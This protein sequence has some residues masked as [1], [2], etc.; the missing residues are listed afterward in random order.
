MVREGTRFMLH[1]SHANLVFMYCF[2]LLASF[3][4]FSAYSK[5]NPFAAVVNNSGKSPFGIP[6]TG[7]GI[8]GSGFGF[9]SS[10]I[11]R[12][13]T[14]PSPRKSPN[15]NPFP[16]QNPKHNPFMTIVDSEVDLWKTMSTSK[17]KDSNIQKKDT[18]HFSSF[19]SSSKTEMNGWGSGDKKDALQSPQIDKPD[20][21]KNEGEDDECDIL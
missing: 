6:S 10:V 1:L 19:L 13:N 7:G 18:E 8:F 9:S 15:N 16:T 17:N 14:M 2:R 20:D 12:S 21:E 11:P 5:V 3:G 4:G